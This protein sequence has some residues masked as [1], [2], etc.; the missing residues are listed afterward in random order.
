MLFDYVKKTYP[1]R[2]FVLRALVFL[3]FSGRVSSLTFALFSL[4]ASEAAEAVFGSLCR[5]M[6]LFA[7]VS[8]VF[9]LLKTRT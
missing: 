1:E 6:H 8:V 5:K 4:F 3:F 9:F 7:G 2:F